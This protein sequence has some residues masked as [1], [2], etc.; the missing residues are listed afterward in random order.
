MTLATIALNQNQAAIGKIHLLDALSLLNQVNEKDAMALRIREMKIKALTNL[1]LAERRMGNNQQAK[2]GYESAIAES[3]HLMEL[4]PRVPSHSWNLVVASLNSG[5]PDMELGNLEDLVQ[6]WQQTV[7][8]LDTLI[9]GEPENQRYVQV[10]AM[11]QS[12]IAIVLRDMGKLEEAIAPL[13]EATAILLEQAKRVEYSP[14]AYLPVALNHYEIATTW[15]R[16][17]QFEKAAD[18]L[19]QSD[20]IVAE[21]LERESTFSPARGHQVDSIHA[22]IGLLSKQ[23]VST[24]AQRQQIALQGI[25]AATELTASNPEVVE[26]QI[27]LCRAKLDLAEV[28]LDAGRHSESIPLVQE[29]QK[30]LIDLQGNQNPSPPDVTTLLRNAYLIEAQ[31]TLKGIT[32]SDEREELVQ[33]LI[34]KAK[35][36]G[37]SDEEIARIWAIPKI[38]D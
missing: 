17:S 23:G 33:N 35:A 21:I 29:S 6:R 19:D 10:K 3:R 36:H 16:L 15:T 14:S 18:A 24:L 5:G 25:Q 28:Y 30:Q 4:E 37:A 12:N 22:R 27:K 2:L 31:A 20:K 9:K 8:V 26:N 7:P 11:L 38:G 32:E 34:E 1:A 13:N